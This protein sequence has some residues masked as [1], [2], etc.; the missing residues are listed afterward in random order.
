MFN[1][2]LSE[3]FFAI[4]AM[5]LKKLFFFSLK[6][7]D[8]FAEPVSLTFKESKKISTKSGSFFTLLLIIM[9]I[10]I[11]NSKLESIIN[12]STVYVQNFAKS[13]NTPPEINMKNRFAF[14]FSIPEL[15]AINGKRY[16]DFTIGIGRILFLKNGTSIS[17]N[18]NLNLVKCNISHFPML[19][20]QELIHSGINDWICPDYNDET[21]DFTVKGTFG[22][23]EYKYIRI[24]V[25]SCSNQTN[26]DNESHCVSEE[27]FQAMRKNNSKIYFDLVFI[28]NLID[29]NDF[30][31]PYKPIVEFPA[32]LIEPNRTFIQNE[33]YFQNTT[34]STDL[35]Q[36][37]NALRSE[38][39]Y[40]NENSVIFN[41]KIDNYLLTDI[42]STGNLHA[43]IFLR[44]DKLIQTFVRKYD[45]FQDYL[46]SLGSFYSVFFL[47]F[48]AINAYFSRPFKTNEIADALYNFNNDDNKKLPNNQNNNTHQCKYIINKFLNLW[49]LIIGRAKVHG[50][51]FQ[52]VEKQ[53]NKDL[54][55]IQMI[56]NLKRLN[57]MKQ[58][59]INEKQRLILDLTGKETFENFIFNE[60]NKMLK[61]F[62]RFSNMSTFRGNFKKSN[63]SLLNKIDQS[64]EE[65]KKDSKNEISKKIC[66]IIDSNNILKK[67]VLI[68]DSK[69]AQTPKAIKPFSFLDQSNQSNR[70]AFSN[71]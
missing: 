55:I 35:T 9:V 50:Y 7:F 46:Q 8:L 42:S 17:T 21:I 16:F 57:N 62:Q 40:L 56:L 24:N 10:L 25:K 64:F 11:S 12:R 36:T 14:Y 19:T 52:M 47:I 6:K 66:Q 3:T 1:I 20:E 22:N 29:L 33:I 28:N 65:L 39:D 26:I 68:F 48:S 58:V 30:S 38:A 51:K 27:E 15:G 67:S 2:F 71:E 63:E 70:S 23:Q 34:I 37:F 53:V 5:K 41:G 4:A 18:Q 13:T 31:K 49:R 61:F 32:I 60:R 54:D 44:S 45:C 69:K 43:S 59:L